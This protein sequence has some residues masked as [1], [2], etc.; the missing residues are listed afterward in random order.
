MSR[1]Y[2]AL[3]ELEQDILDEIE[4]LDLPADYYLELVGRLKEV[5]DI[6]D[7]VLKQDTALVASRSAT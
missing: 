5:R 1:L 6:Q 3:C 4:D 7:S 2:E